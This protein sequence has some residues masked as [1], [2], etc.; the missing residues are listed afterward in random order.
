[1][2]GGMASEE[3]DSFHFLITSSSSQLH[4]FHL[5][6]SSA[7]HIRSDNL[8]S[9]LLVLYFLHSPLQ[10]TWLPAADLKQT[11]GNGRHHEP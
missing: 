8:I 4:T 9:A 2:K 5:L 7:Y 1:M 3:A 6:L 10:I 11:P